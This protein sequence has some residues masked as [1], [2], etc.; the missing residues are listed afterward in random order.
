V[1]S[2]VDALDW[3]RTVNDVS[4]TFLSPSMSIMPGTRTGKFRIG[5]EQ[6]IVDAQ[7]RSAISMEDYA[8][9]ML[10]EIENPRHINA[11]FT[12]GY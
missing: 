5:T 10:D 2:A 12:V 7:G 9:A 11:R 1:R 8:V 4:W 6:L 3:L